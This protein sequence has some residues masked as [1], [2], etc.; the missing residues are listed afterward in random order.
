MMRIH[1]LATLL[2][3]LAPVVG[4]A[5]D[6]GPRVAERTAREAVERGPRIVQKAAANYPSHRSC[7][8]CHHQT[9]PIFAMVEAREG[10]SR[11]KGTCSRRRPT[12]VASRSRGASSR[13]RRGAG[14]A[15]GR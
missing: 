8:S 13:W 14:S 7:F 15:A 1:L 2:F 3:G 11:S 9:L 12:S 5:D 10:G 4:A 6:S